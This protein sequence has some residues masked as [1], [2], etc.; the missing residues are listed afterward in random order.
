M[1]KMSM[2]L[3]LGLILAAGVVSAGEVTTIDGVPTVINGA[4]P[5][6]GVGDLKL[7]ELW[8]RGGEDDEIIFGL[9]L[10]ALSDDAGNVYVLDQQLCEVQVFDPSGDH[11]ATLSRE[12]DGPGEVRQPTDMIWMPDGS[13]GL[14]QSFP[15]RIIK[16]ERDGTPSAP[17][18]NMPAGVPSRSTLMMRP[19]KLWTRPREPSGI[20]IMSVG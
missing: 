10:K 2:I 14:V 4:K 11:L 7:T 8:R 16:V 3:V 17:V 5:A 20:Q 19:G 12:G 13:L 6:D 9:V 18:L 15:G 1:R